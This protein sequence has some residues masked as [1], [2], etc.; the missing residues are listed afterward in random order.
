M[1]ET[2]W[3][4]PS[5][6][7][8]T[9]ESRGGY[10]YHTLWPCNSQSDRQAWTHR[11]TSTKTHRQMSTDTQGDEHRH[12]EDDALNEHWTNLRFSVYWHQYL[13]SLTKKCTHPHTLTFTLL[14]LHLQWLQSGGSEALFSSTTL[15]AQCSC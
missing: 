15:F 5:G 11:R 8:F 14:P 12:A 13:H 1:P 9:G 7:I 6:C 3:S 10:T 2:T 4:T